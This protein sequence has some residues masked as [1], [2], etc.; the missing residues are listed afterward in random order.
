MRYLISIRIYTLNVGNKKKKKDFL[1]LVKKGGR[2]VSENRHHVVINCFGTQGS[3]PL[4]IT[5]FLN[6]GMRER[7]AILKSNKWLEQFSCIEFL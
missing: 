3:C 7:E 1:G 4:G 5:I 2:G 6:F